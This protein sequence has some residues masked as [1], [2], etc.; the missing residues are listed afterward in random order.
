MKP[1][2]AIAI[3]A[4]TILTLV[5]GSFTMSVMMSSGNHANCLAAIPGSPKCPGGDPLQLALMHINA[6]L[7]ASLGIVGTL[8]TLLLA[9]LA[10][11]IWF[12]VPEVLRMEDVVS[13][14]LRIF[15]EEYAQSIKK[16]RR[17]I[18]RLEKRDPSF[19]YAMN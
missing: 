10:L 12:A 3:I 16:Q 19:V 1:T 17:W 7:S 4:I 8:A 11:L 2:I 15:S 14:S 9:A 6:F 5:A 13:C 18:T